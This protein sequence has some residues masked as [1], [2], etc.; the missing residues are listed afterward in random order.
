MHG[1]MNVKFALTLSMKSIHSLATSHPTCPQNGLFLIH[2]P[3][4]FQVMTDSAPYHR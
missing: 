1:H 4:H 3:R 2:P